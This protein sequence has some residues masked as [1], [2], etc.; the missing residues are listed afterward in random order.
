MYAEVI[1]SRRFPKS[2]G[3]F[4][5]KVPESLLSRIRV[6]HLVSI[7]FRK[8]AAEGVV[9][10]LKERPFPGVSIKTLTRVI[11]DPPLLT[12]QQLQLAQWMSDYYAVSIG[13]VIKSM[14][15]DIPKRS[16]VRATLDWPKITPTTSIDITRSEQPVLVWIESVRSRQDWYATFLAR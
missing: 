5:Y 3:V 15:P 13:T 2:M 14:I 4:D 12:D 8:S 7:P 11:D 9:V 6:G 10:R 1:L 16:R